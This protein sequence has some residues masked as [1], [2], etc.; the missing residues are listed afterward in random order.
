MTLVALARRK[1]Q[2]LGPYKS[3]ALLF[4]PLLFVEPLKIAGLAFASLGHWV[5]G[6]CMIVGAYAAGLLVVDRLFRVVK[7]KLLTMKWFAALATAWVAARGK[8]GAWIS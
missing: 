4:V 8:A 6:A 1:I 3:L 2:Q 7:S 5:G